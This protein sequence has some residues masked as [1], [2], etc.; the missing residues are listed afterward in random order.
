M[1]KSRNRIPTKI[2]YEW[3]P[4]MLSELNF[5]NIHGLSN[6]SCGVL[7]NPDE[8]ASMTKYYKLEL[9]NG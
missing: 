2:K 8:F 9:S 6:K 4:N 5:M 3:K 1:T 7:E